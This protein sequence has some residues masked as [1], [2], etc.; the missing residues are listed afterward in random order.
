MGAKKRADQEITFLLQTCFYSHFVC[1]GGG[2][3]NC[4]VH[5]LNGQASLFQNYLVHGPHTGCTQEE[6]LSPR[7]PALLVSPF[8]ILLGTTPESLP[9]SELLATGVSEKVAPTGKI[10][11]SRLESEVVS[12]TS[13]SRLLGVLTAFSCQL[14]TY[15]KEK[16][17]WL[18]STQVFL[19]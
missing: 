14:H 13:T 1:R 8:L 18:K 12:S 11:S 5:N 4:P 3:H 15:L 9:T 16:L 7:A 6:K 10:L 2:A 17:P 19:N